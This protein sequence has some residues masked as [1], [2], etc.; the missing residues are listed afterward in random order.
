MLFF[1]PLNQSNLA[2]AGLHDGNSFA[3]AYEWAGQSKP[4]IVQPFKGIIYNSEYHVYIHMNLYEQDVEVPGQELFGKLPGYFGDS[5]DSRKWLFTSAT[6]KNHVAR[7]AITNDYGSE[8]LVATLTFDKATSTYT[9]NQTEGSD[10]KIARNRRFKKIPKTLVFLRK[11][12][13][14]ADSTTI[15]SNSLSARIKKSLTSVPLLPL[16]SL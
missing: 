11:T 4:E 14:A 6:I 3:S 13:Q 15:A 8:D 2:M 1:S 9:L 16:R 7:I 10:I 12:K 5:L